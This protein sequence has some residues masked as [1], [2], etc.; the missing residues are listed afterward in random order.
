MTTERLAQ[1]TSNRVANLLEGV[2]RKLVET[3]TRNRLIHVNR[4]NLRSNTLNIINKRSEDVFDILRVNSRRMKFKAIGKDKN[5]E[6]DEL[7]LVEEEAPPL[8]EARSRDLVLETPLGPDALGK[9]L[10]R[11]Y[12]DA[13]TAEDEQGIN[14][15]YLSM[16]FLT[17]FED[18]SSSIAREAPLILLPVELERN[19]RGSTFN[20]R[21]REDD[22]VTNLPLQER[23]KADGVLLPEIDDSEPWTPEQYFARVAKEISEKPGWNID[24]DGMQIGFFSFAKLLMLRDLEPDNWPNGSL[25]EKDLVQRL[26]YSG[27]DSEPPL[28]NPNKRLDDQLNPEDIF[29]VVD[30]DASQAKVIEEVRSGRNLIVQGPPGTGKSQTITNI[31]ASA[32][33]DGKSVIFMAEKM[34]A[35]EVVHNR[36]VKVG[37]RDLCLELHSRNANKKAV[38]GEL[39]RT[40]LSGGSISGI[41]GDSSKLRATR[42]RLNQIADFLHQPLPNRDYSPFDAMTEISGFIGK[43]TPPPKL[44]GNGLDNL[45]RLDR[46]RITNLIQKHA[47]T[48]NQTGPRIDHPFYGVTVYD[49]QPTDLQRL[50]REISAALDALSELSSITSDLAERT[51]LSVAQNLRDA[52]NLYSILGLLTRMP[53][54]IFNYGPIL[55]GRAGECRLEEALMSASDWKI[56]RDVAANFFSDAAWEA[57]VKALRVPISQ[58]VGSLFLRIFGKYRAASA[59]FASLLSQPIPK[60]PAE[61]LALLDQLMIVQ[62]KRAVLEEDKVFLESV[63][64]EVWRGE[65]TDFD[66]LISCNTWLKELSQISAVQSLETLEAMHVLASEAATLGSNLKNKIALVRQA[67]CAVF[68]RLGYVDEVETE[69]EIQDLSKLHDRFTKMGQNLTRYAEWAQLANGIEKLTQE[70]LTSLIKIIDTKH[71][72]PEAAA[73]EFLY[74]TAEARWNYARAILPELNKLAQLNRHHLVDVFCKLDCEQFHNVRVLIREKHLEQ[75]PKGASGEMGYIL[76]EIAKKRNHKPIRKLINSA[77]SMVRRIKPVFLM[78]PISI[79]QFLP[80]GSIDFDLLVM[81][82]ASQVRPEDAIGAVARTKQIVVVGDQKQ[83]PPTNFFARL[84][85]NVSD[86]DEDEEIV[87]A[88]GVVPGAAKATEMESILT[89]CEAR[90]LNSSMLKWHYRSRDPSLIQISNT[91]F[92]ENRLVLPPSPLQFDDNFGLKYTRVPGIYSSKSRGSGR[93]GTNRIEAESVASALAD[94]ARNWPELSVGVV[95]FSKAQS[96]MVTEILEIARRKDTV[97][98]NFLRKVKAEDVFVKNIENVQG[99]ERDVIFISVGYGPHEPNGRLATMHFGPVNSEGGERRLN[100]LFSRARVRCKVFVSFDPGDI[101]LTRISRDGPRVLKRFLEFAKS[102]NLDQRLISGFEADSPF[103]EDVAQVITSLGYPVD[104]QVGSSGFRIDLGVRHPEQTG[105]FILAVE[106][107]GA[108]WHSAL[109]ARERDRLRQAILEDLGWR[110]HRI[111]STDWFHRRNQEID[112]LQSALEEAKNLADKGISVSGTNLSDGVDTTLPK[113]PEIPSTEDFG[114][115]LAS[116]LKVPAYQK[117]RPQTQAWIGSEPHEVPVFQ[118]AEIVVEIVKSEGPIHPE[119]VTRR[120]ASSF[121]KART[122]RRIQAA[123]NQALIKAKL[124]EQVLSEGGFWLTAE[125]K[126]EPPVRDRTAETQPTTKAIYLCPLEIRAAAAMIENENGAVEPVEMIRAVARLLGYLRAGRDLQTQIAMALDLG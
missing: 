86:E 101:D 123:V 53:S 97:L 66:G 8:D 63:L 4:T 96:N 79:A 15:L 100:V 33:H 108:T 40:L 31:I 67:L 81:D 1:Q 80:P 78:S 95:T 65:L 57:S 5:D 112:R 25:I 17:W 46:H 39:K 117:A 89:L 27:F 85:D 19:E 111:W 98:D 29:H 7:S 99:D 48:L 116:S 82:E 26:L 105:Q 10:P 13:K 38:L 51:G 113:E 37:L 75:L 87:G 68:D 43:N 42:D 54:S 61:C 104:P 103:E 32:V 16:G 91:E 88:N 76:G 118:L 60:A 77:G 62:Q 58:G 74:A 120:I 9:R 45:T 23:L 122:G 124:Q 71:L 90:G 6:L 49:L 36:M 83:L 110:F 102:G 59:E 64:G 92:Y 12:T 52:D 70:G 69:R 126:M 84:T 121:G 3:G 18:H 125:Q 21:A 11:L 56:A 93:P 2:R 28:F 14:I 20:I 34:A 41:I 22:V 24:T 44:E 73:N 55:F 109:W 114:T 35:L 50:S 30:A 115:V 106:C 94:H 47:T 72:S 107:D 119:E